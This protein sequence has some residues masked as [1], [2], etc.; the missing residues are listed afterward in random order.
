MIIMC[1]L[2]MV[3]FIIANTFTLFIELPQEPEFIYARVTAYAP[4]DNVGGICADGNPNL[5]STGVVPGKDI[6]AVD[7]AR[8][9]YGTKLYIPGFGVVEAGDTGGALRASDDICIDI[10]FDTHEE[11]TSWGVQWLRVRVIRE[12]IIGYNGTGNRLLKEDLSC[13]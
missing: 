5:T 10:Y 13:I 7:P 4:H 8:L 12:K 11:A 3:I 1:Q 9:P 2:Y 6:C